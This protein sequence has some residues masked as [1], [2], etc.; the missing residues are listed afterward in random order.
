MSLYIASLLIQSRCEKSTGCFLWLGAKAGD[1]YGTITYKGMQHYTHRL[2]YEAVKGPVGNS[3]V[4]H[5]CDNPACCNPD[6][7]F[8]GSQQDNMTDKRLKG[9]ARKD[10]GENSPIS[11]LTDELVTKIYLQKGKISGKKLAKQLGLGNT[12]VYYIWEKRRW[13]HVTDKLDRA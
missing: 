2:M 4:L 9:R 1:G 5:T 7:L 8:L 12:I 13:T 10:V 6:H 11:K 3:F